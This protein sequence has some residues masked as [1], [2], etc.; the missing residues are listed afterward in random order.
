MTRVRFG[1]GLALALVLGATADLGAQPGKAPP[2][3]QFKQFGATPEQFW[4]SSV[5]RWTGELTLDIEAVKT[6][7]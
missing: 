5:Q 2:A 4:Q 3:V 7:V 1:L 6:D